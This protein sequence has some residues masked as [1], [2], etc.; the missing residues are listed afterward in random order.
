MNGSKRYCLWITE[1]NKDLAN[2]ISPIKL[3]I[4]L[5]REFRLKSKKIAT[6]KKANTPYQ[7]DETNF[8]DAPSLFIPQTGSEKREYVQLDF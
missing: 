5:C 3:R 1:D 2:S 8:I 6:V 7:F 4:E